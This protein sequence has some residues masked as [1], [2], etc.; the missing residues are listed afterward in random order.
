MNRLQ[1]EQSNAFVY[2]NVPA[3]CSLTDPSVG[4]VVIADESLS[5]MALLLFPIIRVFS[6]SVFSAACLNKIEILRE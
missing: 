4:E 1:H 3:V 5:P 2:F 6:S